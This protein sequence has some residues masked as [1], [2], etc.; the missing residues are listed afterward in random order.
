MIDTINWNAKNTENLFNLFEMNIS[1]ELK[2][3]F[4]FLAS[5]FYRS[6]I[7]LL[8]SLYLILYL[9][10]HLTLSQFLQNQNQLLRSTL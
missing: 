7:F 5:S 2:Y 9:I 6:S 3:L 10:I 4:G 1:V 8:L